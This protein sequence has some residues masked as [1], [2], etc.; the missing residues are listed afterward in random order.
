M[1]RILAFGDNLITPAMLRAGLQAFVEHGD[2]VEIRDWSHA[3]VEDL[4]RDNIKV[5]QEGANAVAIDDAS[6]LDGIED[7][8]MVITQFT[9][10]GRAVIER[11][12]QLKYIGVLRGGTENVDHAAAKEHGVEIL[13]TPGSECARRCRIHGRHDPG[14][15][16]EYCQ[17]VQQN[18]S[19]HLVQRFSEQRKYHRAGR[20]DHWYSWASVISG[21]SLPNSLQ[22]SMPGSF[23][24]I[25]MLRRVISRRRS[26]RSR[27]W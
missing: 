3:S 22:R 2:T 23:S 25:L 10:I 27:R 18:A 7:F 26:I 9:P 13:P 8:D 4:Q 12:R 5:E 16:K 21:S 1:M 15:D 24:T 20:E 19:R 14:G 17:D 11:A 6:L